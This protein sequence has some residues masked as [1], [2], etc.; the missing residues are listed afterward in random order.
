MDRTKILIADDHAVVR[1]SRVERDGTPSTLNFVDNVVYTTTGDLMAGWDGANDIGPIGGVFA[2]NL[3]Y[4]PDGGKISGKSWAD[5]AAS[6]RESGGAWGDPR[7]VDAAKFD[8]R[9]RP[10]SPAPKTGFKP[11]DLTGVGSTLR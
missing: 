2:N 3:W 6:G 10:D 5:W 8:F 9:L 1:I 11:F 4:R 7:F